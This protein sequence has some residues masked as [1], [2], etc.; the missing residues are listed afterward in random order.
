MKIT[1]D[2]QLTKVKFFEILK[3]LGDLQLFTQFYDAQGLCLKAEG[4]QG[5]FLKK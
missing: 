1:F 5:L 4:L 2:D 3:Q